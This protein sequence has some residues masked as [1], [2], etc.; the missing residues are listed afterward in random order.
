MSPLFGALMVLTAGATGGPVVLAVLGLALVAV[1][2]GLA[3][4]RAATGAVLLTVVALALSDPSPLFAAVSGLSAAAYLVT[5]HGTLTIPTVA[6]LIG[7]TAAGVV[8]TAVA[9][10]V[11]WIPLLAPAVIAGVLIVAA[12]P[13][14]GDER[15]GDIRA[16]WSDRRESG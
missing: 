13:L 12:L 5:R 16:P 9:L 1:A 8:A 14:L 2:A 11:S 3:D 7:F 4:R 10:P 15:T 6:G